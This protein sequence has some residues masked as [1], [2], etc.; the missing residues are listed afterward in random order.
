MSEDKGRILEIGKPEWKVQGRFN[1]SVHMRVTGYTDNNVPIM[2]L[3]YEDG[4]PLAPDLA[5]KVIDWLSESDAI[6]E[7]EDDNKPD[8]A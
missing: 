2:Q 7:I 5:Q 4:T 1:P 8:T 6:E 3:Q